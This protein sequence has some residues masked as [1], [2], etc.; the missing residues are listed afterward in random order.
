MVVPVKII[1]NRYNDSVSFLKY[2]PFIYQEEG[3]HRNDLE[4]PVSV[5]SGPSATDGMAPPSVHP[6]LSPPEHVWEECLGIPRAQH[7]LECPP[8]PLNYPG[9]SG[10]ADDL[11]T[12]EFLNQLERCID[13]L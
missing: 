12:S 9:T 8:S 7:I 1:A 10:A 13:E 5:A 2:C 11:E 4:H 6:L 3:I